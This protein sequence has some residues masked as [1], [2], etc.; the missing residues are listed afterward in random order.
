MLV[1]ILLPP[2][3]S[4]I[5]KRGGDVEKN[6]DLVGGFMKERTNIYKIN[7]RKRLHH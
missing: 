6:N 7:N 2:M 1:L 5:F 4:R 3:M